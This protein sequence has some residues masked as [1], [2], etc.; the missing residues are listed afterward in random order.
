MNPCDPHR[1]YCLSNG[2]FES[3]LNA[4]GNG[5]LKARECFLTSH[6]DSGDDGLFFFVR[7]RQTGAA[8][9]ATPA[10]IFAHPDTLLMRVGARSAH[11]ERQDGTIV[12]SLDILVPETGDFEVRRLTL[13]NTGDTPR[14]LEVT[15]VV[16]VILLFDR[17]RDTRHQTFSNM[18]IGAEFSEDWHALIYHRRFF[19]NPEH[20]PIFMHRIFPDA[21]SA[22]LGF[23][24]DREAFIGRGHS[25][26]R[27]V[28]LSRP[29]K[30]TEGY[31]LDP[32]ASLRA[33]VVLDPG[34]S[35]S[36]F[37]SNSAHF[38]PEQPK[39]FSERFPDVHSIRTFF[40][41]EFERDQASQRALPSPLSGIPSVPLRAPAT[42]EEVPL[43]PFD[44]S[45]LLFWNGFGGFDPK[46]HEY[47]MRI[48]P[49]DLPPQPWANSIAN[50]TFGTMTTENALGTTWFKNSKHG[51]LTPWS[52]NPVTDPPAAILF[53]RRKDTGETWSLTPSPLPASSE[54]HVTHGR[55][56]TKYEGGRGALRHTLTVSVSPHHPIE[57]LAVELEHDE[58]SPIDIE[59]LFFMDTP[60]EECSDTSILPPSPR[61]LDTENALILDPA[62]PS[63]LSN[64]EAVR[65]STLLTAD[66]PIALAA[67]SKHHLFGVSGVFS[68][69]KDLP[70]SNNPPHPESPMDACVAVRIRHTL[71]ARH[72]KRITLAMCASETKET[73]A[74]LLSTI[75]SDLRRG[76]PFSLESVHALWKQVDATPTIAT[77]DASLNILFNTWVP[78]QALVS[79]MWAKMGFYQ[80]GGAFG[81]RDQ[82]QDALALWY[83]NP[84]MARDHILAAAAQQFESGDVRAWWSPDSGYG[85]KNTASDHPLW[86]AW[87]VAEY[88]RRS[89]ES[90][91]LDT[92]IGF[93]ADDTDPHTEFD[94][95]RHEPS[96][97]SATL[98]EHCMKAIDVASV[99][100]EHGLPLI[101]GGDWNDGF[102]R[103]GSEGKGESIW[104]GFFLFS[105]LK[106]FADILFKQGNKMFSDTL[107]E[108]ALRLQR[109]L[110]EKGWDGHWFLR[111]FYDDGTL[112]GTESSHECRID[113]I[114]QVWSVLSGAGDPEKSHEA[115]ENLIRFLYDPESKILKLLDPPFND[116][117]RKNPGYIKD[118]P[119]GIRE[120]GSQYNHAVFWAAEAFA[121][122]GNTDMVFPLL[123][124]ANPIHRSDSED[125]ARL[126]EVEPY[127]VAADIYSAEHR[128]KGG[129][130]WYTAS[131]GL[132]YRTIIETLFGIRLE[133]NTVSIRPAFPKHWTHATITL[134][135][136]HGRYTFVFTAPEN[137]TNTL[138]DIKLDGPP[139]DA[140]QSPYAL[141]ADGQYHRFEIFLE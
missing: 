71:P 138:R 51:R 53:L 127:V 70:D 39:H 119:P 14:Q 95:K 9:S 69:P 6:R 136:A 27:P 121:T 63:L 134:P 109:N 92:E 42:K 117:S 48:R 124:C 47:R 133:G 77:P 41:S 5:Y 101:R 110:N 111:A 103:V 102:N 43:P 26:G 28:A 74:A 125:A 120:N 128:G 116:L 66:Q 79:R 8:W 140:S 100:G 130:T 106:Q 65:F 22:F 139:P 114:A 15:S 78:Y 118:Y 32:L 34:E 1:E 126:Y 10:P 13:T 141:P 99:F 16:D 24:T 83:I 113:A 81:F 38:A 11:I 76:E 85:V 86:L 54:Y 90:A 33:V 56:F 3:R 104:L 135:L 49:E 108:R 60:N 105:I 93:L 46:T 4:L 132:L 82:L 17:L 107:Q 73:Q 52:N 122:L 75:Q 68:I 88:I 20:F 2:A 91:I 30:N 62:P 61:F 23:E 21:P 80:P 115:L 129:W 55:G 112:L 137:H 72:T 29:L 94:V 87:T 25:L 50:P 45:A 131:A 19:D 64:K 57:Y 44:T 97:R 123:D 98:L 40:S 7:D 12:T 58:E 67:L 84:T 96:G 35:A 89:G 18:F 59:L 31:I 37:F 36:I